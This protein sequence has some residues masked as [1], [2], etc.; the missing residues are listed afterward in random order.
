VSTDARPGDYYAFT[1]SPNGYAAIGTTHEFLWQTARPIS[2]IKQGSDAVN[3]IRAECAGDRLTLFVNDEEVKSL[4]DTRLTT[5]DIGVTLENYDARRTV[6]A[7]FDD[8][9]VK[10][11]PNG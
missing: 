5:G 3:T 6:T 9:R 10:T 8:V 7:R 1:I 2:A 4:T 11:V